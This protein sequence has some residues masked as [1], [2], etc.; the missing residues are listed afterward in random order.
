MK[1]ALISFFAV[2]REVI[3]TTSLKFSAGFTKVLSSFIVV[4]GLITSLDNLLT[5]K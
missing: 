2:L 3:A 4:V 1:T 5:S